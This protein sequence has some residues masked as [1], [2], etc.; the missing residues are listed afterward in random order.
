MTSKALWT[1]VL[2]VGVLAVGGLGFAAFTA[3][4][5]VNLQGTAGNLGLTFENSNQVVSSSYVVCSASTQPGYLNVTAGPFAPGDW[6][7]VFAN[8]TNSG[9]VPAMVTW[10]S[11]G[12][13]AC[14]DWAVLQPIADT[15][16]TLA[17][18]GTLAF[19]GALELDPSAGNSCENAVGSLSVSFSA[20]ASNS[21]PG[22][23]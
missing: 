6:C 22:L 21:G 23:L 18:G 12:T 11:S 13:G 14:F 2:I 15:S 19:Q 3:S 4:Y 7:E 16:T 1:S 8:V 9:N 5:Q 10:S 17:P 20:S